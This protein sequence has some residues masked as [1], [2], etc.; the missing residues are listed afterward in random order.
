MKPP[1]GTITAINLDQ[2]EIVWQIARVQVRLHRHH[3]A[4]DVYPYRC[5]NDR[6]TGRG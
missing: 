3:P 2:G 5:R 1:Y 4:A 6:A